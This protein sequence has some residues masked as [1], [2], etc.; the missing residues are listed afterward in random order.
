M[1]KSIA[2]LVGLAYSYG[3]WKVTVSTPQ[4]ATWARQERTELCSRTSEVAADIYFT[5]ACFLCVCV[6]ERAV[7]K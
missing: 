2:H 1:L 3:A 5:A 7:V 4:Q 6:C